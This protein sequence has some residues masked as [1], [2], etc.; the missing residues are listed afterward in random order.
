M[1]QAPGGRGVATRFPGQ[2]R[3]EP[4]DQS[5]CREALDLVRYNKAGFPIVE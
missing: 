5:A 4:P 2:V 1:G 3:V